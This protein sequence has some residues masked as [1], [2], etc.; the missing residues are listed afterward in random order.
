MFLAELGFTP[1]ESPS[2]CG[3][4]LAANTRQK[5]PKLCKTDL[6]LFPVLRKLST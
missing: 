5:T 6:Q 3:A 1:S 2:F 4:K